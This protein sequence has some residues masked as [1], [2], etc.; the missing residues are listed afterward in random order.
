M[1]SDQQL[2]KL[3]K[4]FKISESVVA[5]E[6][7]QVLFLK[8]LYDE[9]FSKHIYFKGGTAIRL[10]F[11]GSRF[12]EDLDFTVEG[13]R[14]DFDEFV[15]GFFGKLKKLYGFSF[16][17][18][19]S[20]V[21]LRYLL[22]YKS[23]LTKGGV[24]INLDFSFREKVLEPKK[25]IIETRYPVVFRSFVVHLS[26]EEMVAEKVRAVMKREKGR[27]IY[28]LWFLFSKNFEID[29]PMVEKKLAYYEIERFEPKQLLD[30]VKKFSR[31][32]FVTDLRPFVPIGERDKLG[33]LFD[34]AV[35]V[36]E[37]KVRG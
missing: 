17:N 15:E 34:Y 7:V 9:N 13:D 19:D 26:A 16:K 20:L 27:D 37:K 25:S 1:I 30:R 8:E 2:K 22:T 10:V 24:F 3:S 11:D 36:I 14:S 35:A 29:V 18:R 6:F 21:G 4:D 12:S 28:D 5:R 32:K 31:E 23:D 33:E